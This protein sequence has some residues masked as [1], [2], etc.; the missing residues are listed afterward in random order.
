M[1][2]KSRNV[3]TEVKRANLLGKRKMHRQ[4]RTKEVVMD[5]PQIQTPQ[6]THMGRGL[7][8]KRLKLVAILIQQLDGLVNSG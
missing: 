4:H 3:K 2:K 1:S 6:T 5:P 7:R 8:K